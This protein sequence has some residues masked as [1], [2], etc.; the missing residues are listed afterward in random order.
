MR[1]FDKFALYQEAHD[2]GDQEEVTHLR[3]DFGVAD[4]FC[5][6]AREGGLEDTRRLLDKQSGLVHGGAIMLCARE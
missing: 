4:L 5:D 2:R 1:A 6:L 3:G